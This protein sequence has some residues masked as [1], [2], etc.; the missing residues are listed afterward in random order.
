MRTALTVHLAGKP[1]AEILDAGSGETAL[2]Y[3]P[4]AM[5]TPATSRLSLS[6]PVRDATYGTFGPGGRWVRSLLPEGRALD[7][8]VTHFGI[9]ADDR[10]GLIATLGRDVAGAAQV[11]PQDESPDEQGTYEKLSAEALDEWVTRAD[12]AP[13]GLDRH[14]GV[15]LSLA[16]MQDKVV[17]HRDRND[18][19]LPLEGAPST[20]IVKPEPPKPSGDLPGVEGVVT[21]E[22]FCLRLARAADLDA[23]TATIEHF[24]GKP[25]LVV[26]RYDRATA[27]TG[28]VVRVHQEDLL[29]VLGADPL[30]KYERP[31]SMRLPVGG[32]FA[33]PATAALPG[34]TARD[35]ARALE[36]HVGA[37]GLLAVL[38]ALVLNMAVGNADAHARNLS[39]LLNRDG[40]VS[41]APL[42]DIVST[43]LWPHLDPEP[44]QLVA[45]VDHID[46]VTVEHI[47]DECDGWG[48]PRRVAANRT[49][50]LL[51]RLRDAL[52]LTT[53]AVVA[54]GGDADVA[55]RLG[56]LIAQRIDRMR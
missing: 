6:L 36:P 44:A 51:N 2:R 56:S 40:S 3:L 55:E 19:Y 21:N 24:A 53:E 26:D 41:L 42:Y 12:R 28:E 33:A 37:I 18:W 7:W 17:L 4:D 45:G 49:D 25:A 23:A 15:R 29:G 16:G 39:V 47:L 54:D 38:D 20:I 11:L 48:V 46:E 50:Q 22:A 34:P 1:V 43:R 30:L 5:M 52:P 8:A 9:P 13:L 35:L 14:R 27:V 32:G 10:F 31:Q